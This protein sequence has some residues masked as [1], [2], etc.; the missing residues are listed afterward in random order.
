MSSTFYGATKSVEVQVPSG[1]TTY[2]NL[3]GSFPSNVTLT[4]F[5]S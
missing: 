3:S 2:T 1:S 4:T 5:T